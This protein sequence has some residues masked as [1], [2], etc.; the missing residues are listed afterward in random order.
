[1]KKGRIGKMILLSFVIILAVLLLGAWSMFGTQVT[2]ARTVTK[3]DD[4]LYTMTYRGDYGFDQFLA[5]GGADSD[6]KM[7]EYIISFLSHGFYTPKGSETPKDFACSSLSASSPEG[8]RVFGRNYDW[9]NC[10]AMIVHTV[11]KN[12]Y[13]SISTVCLDF[14]G[15][16]Q[17]WKP[18]GMPNQFMALAAVYLPLDGMNEKGLCVAD[19]MAGDAESTHQDTGKPDLTTV[20][21]IRL[22]LDQAATVEEA[23]A[24]LSQYDMH[25]SI[26]SAHHFAISDA[27][28]NSVVAEWVDGELHVTD[29]P[30][31]TN[32]YLTPGSK[33]GI[34]NEESHN[35]YSRL[36]E[37]HTASQGIL[38]ADA[39]KEAMK[40]VSYEDRTQWS[41]V[42][43]Q[44]A[45]TLDFF[46]QRNFDSGFSYGLKGNKS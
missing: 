16:G 3:L 36:M 41:I 35:R 14:L 2:A 23:V 34:G 21:A 37:L 9:E 25:S 31:V 18:E 22:I 28:G 32:H 46:W 45:L 27:A 33:F 30:A 24:L 38:S 43:D 42:Y 5:Q 13:A 39:M 7:A 15:F 11:P 19:L 26:G 20:S 8:S 4:G 40:A 1:M 44:E 29:T 10:S 17:G 6:A 12:G